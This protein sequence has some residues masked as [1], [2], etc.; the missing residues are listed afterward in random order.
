MA[1]ECPTR[2]KRVPAAGM[3]TETTTA[4]NAD[5]DRLPDGRPDA[6]QAL[7]AIVL[8]HEGGHVGRRLLQQRHGVQ[9]NP[10]T[11]IAAPR[12]SVEKF[13]RKTRSIVSC[14]FQKLLAMMSGHAI[15]RMERQRCRRESIV[16]FGVENA[17][18]RCL[19]T[20][21]QVDNL[22]PPKSKSLQNVPNRFGQQLLLP[23]GYFRVR[24]RIILLQNGRFPRK[25][26]PE[27]RFGA[28]P[29]NIRQLI[30]RRFQG[31]LSLF[32]QFC[33]CHAGQSVRKPLRW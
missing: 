23:Q 32:Q 17:G 4:R 13:P 28:R 24:L 26:V 30:A 29:T 5:I 1:C 12:A 15:W 11:A 27:R 31:L 21:I 22:Y 10:I 16:V 6:I 8:S 33:E 9:N 18:S 2:W 20:F 14:R 3:V 19:R 25:K 7:G